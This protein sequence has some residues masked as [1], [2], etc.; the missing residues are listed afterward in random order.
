MHIV[1]AEIV[2]RYDASLASPYAQV[3]VMVK[4]LDLF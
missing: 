2:G 1:Y 3:H 4:Y